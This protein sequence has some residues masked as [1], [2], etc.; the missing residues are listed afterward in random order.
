MIPSF[1]KLKDNTVHYA[2]HEVILRAEP[3]IAA[4]YAAWGQ[5]GVITAAKDGKHSD[6]SRHFPDPTDPR[7]AQALDLRT[8]VIDEAKREPFSTRLLAFLNRNLA[9]DGRWTG[10]L[11]T[12]PSQHLHI[13]WN[14]N[15][16]VPNVVGYKLG[17]DF[18]RSVT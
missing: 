7:P 1:L 3:I 6:N 13:E 5:D 10:V 4:F 15:G 17:Q 9:L 16:T 2:V 14:P 18:Y 12:G 8:F 11:H